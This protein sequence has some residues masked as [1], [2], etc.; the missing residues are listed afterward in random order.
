MPKNNK[1]FLLFL[2]SFI[3][4]EIFTTSNGKFATDGNDCS[5][6]KEMI[7]IYKLKI[8][9]LEKKIRI[10]SRRIRE[11]KRKEQKKRRKKRRR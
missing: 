6:Y 9:D 5:Q 4:F 11:L 7:E 10:R 2:Y 8:D 1:I 3:N